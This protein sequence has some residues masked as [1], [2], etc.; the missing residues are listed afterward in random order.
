MQNFITI[1]LLLLFG[2]RTGNT[3]SRVPQSTW[4]A[5]LCFRLGVWCPHHTPCLS[6]WC[7]LAATRS[8]PTT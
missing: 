3:P 1:W 5:T 8:P 6:H 7:G 2:V 4:P